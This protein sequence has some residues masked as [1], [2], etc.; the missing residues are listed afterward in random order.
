MNRSFFKIVFVLFSLL[1]L[2][3]PAAVFAPTMPTSLHGTV[4]VSSLHAPAGTGIIAKIG[5]TQKG[6]VAVVTEGSYG[7]GGDP[8]LL[9][10]G[11]PYDYG[12]TITLWVKSPYMQD[13][14]QADQTTIY[15]S[16][17][18]QVDITTPIDTTPPTIS[19]GVNPASLTYD[20]T[21]ATVDIADVGTCSDSGYG[22]HKTQ[23][24]QVSY[25]DVGTTPQAPCNASAIYIVNRNWGTSHDAGFNAT[26]GHYYCIRLD[27]MD[28]LN[29]TGSF[30]S[31][32]NILY[33]ITPPTT[34]DNIPPGW[35][36]SDIT[37]TLTC[38]DTA[39]GCSKVYYTTN[40]TDPTTS[41]DYVD[42]SDSWQFTVST[43]GNHTIKYR[44]EDNAG[45]L[46]PANTATLKIDKTPP[47]ITVTNTSIPNENQTI[48]LNATVIDDNLDTVW[49]EVTVN[50]NSTNYTISTCMG[51]EYHITLESSNYTAHDTVTWQYHANDSPG[52]QGSGPLRAFTVKNRPPSVTAPALNNT[53]PKTDDALSCENGTFSDDDAEDSETGR[54]YRWYDNNTII[55]G[56]TS[57]TLDLSLGGLDKN[58][59][60]KCSIRVYDGYGWSG[61]VYSDTATIQNTAPTTPTSLAL[62]DPV[63]VGE[64]LAAS[65]SGSADAD[66]DPITYHY[67]FYNDTAQLQAYSTD[68]TYLIQA[69]DAHDL[70][71][72]RAKAYDGTSYSGEKENNITVSNTAPTITITEP[73]GTN[74]STKTT[75]TVTWTAT[76]AE[77]DPLAIGCYGDA[78]NSGYDKTYTCFTGT[79]NNG[80]RTCNI[81]LWNDSF[82]Y[83]WC[84]ATDG[85]DS[86]AGYSPG[87]LAVDKTPPSISISDDA[88]ATW[89]NSDT[90]SVTVDDAT[91]GISETKYIVSDDNTCGPAKDALLDAGTPGTSVTANNVSTYQ[92][93]YI[94][95]RT[96]DNAGNKNY[97]VSSQITKLD[98]TSPSTSDNVPSGWHTSDITV[99][100]ACNDTASGCSKVYYTT[101]GT[102][103]TT[104]SGYVDASGIWQFTISTDGEYTIKYRGEDN[105]GNLESVNTAANILRLDKTPPTISIS[106]DAS[107]TWTNS[108]TISVTVDDATSGISE[109][110]YIV[111][112]DN[113]CGPAKDALLDAGTSTT[114]VT[115]NVSA[116]QNK[117][118]CF[119]TKDTAGNKNYAVSSQIT[120]LD[121]TSPSTSDNVPSGWHTSDITVTLACNDTDSGCS[122]VYYTTG[123]TDPTTASGYVDASG[124]WQFTVS[125]DGEYTIKY[126]GEDNA[127]NLESVNTAA[128]T[129]R[130][131][132]TAPTITV[133]NTSIP[134]EDQTIQLNATVIDD[135]LDT[136]WVEVTVNSNSTNYTVSTCID[137]EYHITLESSN[138]TAHDIV[139]WQYHANDS[140]GNLG[141]GPLRTFTVKNQVPSVTA[142]ALN[143]TTPKTDDALSCEN[144]TFSDDDTEDSETGREYRWHNND[145]EIPGQTSHTLDLS[146]GGLDKNDMIKCSIRA[147]DG[148]D[149]SGWVNSD[150][151]AI[152]NTAP[153][154]PAAL[155]LTDPIHV[156]ETLAASGSG[157]ADADGDPITYHYS[158]YND[159]A[160]LQAYS[161]DNTYVILTSD[162]HDQIMV[163]AKAYDGTDYS[164]EKEKN[165]T[166]SNKVPTITITEPD[167]T[168]DSIKATF[169]VTWTATDADTD[170]LA[171]DCYGDADN[172]GYDKTY[173]CF[174][175]TANN[176][177]KTCDI[178]LWND[179]FYYIWCNATDGYDSSAGYSPG[180][181]AVDKTPPTI[182]GQVKDK[183]PDEDENV[184]L[185]ATIID[186]GSG[187][188]T[189]LLEWNR[190]TNYTV[191]TYNGNTY[192]FTVSHG[193]YTAHDL[194]YWR[195]YADDILSNSGVGTEQSFTVANQVPTL[196]SVNANDSYAKN[197]DHIKISTTGASDNDAE[198][199]YRLMC[200]SA[201][202]TYDYCNGTYGTGERECNFINSWSNNSVYTIHCKLYDQ[203]GYSTDR[204]TTSGCAPNWVLNHTWSACIN[205]IQ[206]NEYYD[207]NDCDDTQ[208]KP[209]DVKRYCELGVG[210]YRD[211]PDIATIGE[212]FNVTLTIDV[213]ESN[214]PGV[215][216]LYEHIPEGFEIIDTGGM[217]PSG[218]TLK[219]MVFESAYYGTLVEDRIVTYTLRYVTVNE[220]VFEGIIVY[221]SVDHEVLGDDSISGVADV[222]PPD[223]TIFSPVN[224][225]YDMKTVFLMANSGEVAR[226]MNESIDGASPAFV[227]ADCSYI[228][229]NI[230][231]ENGDHNI[232][233]YAT[234]YAGNTGNATVHFTIDYCEP[235]WV[236]N[237]TWSECVDGFQY[238]NYYDVA[239]CGKP[240]ERPP[241]VVRTC[242]LPPPPIGTFRVLPPSAGIGDEFDVVLNIDV[243]ESIKPNVYIIY[244]TIPAGFSVIDTG[245]MQYTT[246]TR[247]LKLMVY[248]SAYFGTVVE[249]RIVTYRLRADAYPLEVFDG[250]LRYD[251]E[252]HDIMGDI[253]VV[254]E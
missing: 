95:F 129:L 223:V 61:W 31:S 221:D 51:S 171:I 25:A 77:T 33:D 249:D 93:K 186:A 75:F 28:A 63:H 108:D 113:T 117:Y 227:C 180:Q 85:Y 214:K 155:A 184:V 211:L 160:Q 83:I 142:P 235:I 159:T 56:Q 141:S 209:S 140:P 232:T 193:N 72:I 205:T 4:N 126:M 170:P 165:I 78:D 253:W 151:A 22:M 162:A 206:Y 166:V 250:Y 34:S 196:T 224:T 53:T 49:V 248:E 36:T 229:H 138:Y 96:K 99:T 139:T 120:K 194:V 26:D 182:S 234:D 168:N 64:T 5:S 146:L 158:F 39:S 60:I 86:S 152:Q 55:S 50:G 157:S 167:G 179:S 251:F 47:S 19:T 254:V 115:A 58:D 122:K 164:G 247:T 218:N 82:Y 14:I 52:N 239:N 185:N 149:W 178:S 35:H 220:S 150:T 207:L 54:K 134:N 8:Q 228:A 12:S 161:T 244:E 57:Q 131:D 210:I 128:N 106:D 225:T 252:N 144:G 148:Y 10:L 175:G 201:E 41:S 84:N 189:V 21:A 238:R 156:G 13:Y 147:Y 16:S 132:K 73:D 240:E 48:Q 44:G 62:T 15:D 177:S 243:N 208:S 143:N 226:E 67:S 195:Y 119:R 212:V 91:S 174:T 46:E 172:L 200:G 127:G 80:S 112:D 198:D 109:T 118:I 176:G 6:S 116:Y 89:T 94:C 43:D 216:I 145:T 135:N 90:I 237:D 121:T 236:L 173:T 3:M 231:F 203:Y 242:G 230:T 87:Q 114:S 219:L 27:C 68:N 102:D 1:F 124:I 98:T 74:D 37:V 111:S 246:A 190:T 213:N 40:G 38:I 81:S 136:V 163:R 169:T 202:D 9:V 204:T 24:Y 110:K 65:C 125:T 18:K 153:A 88:S 104:S 66:G 215:Y 191:T 79:A 187:L 199:T 181:L 154:T 71:R 2:L 100:L 70:I 188:G 217:S 29:N 241:D 17:V 222:T 101:G 183:T 30:Y 59:M 32:N 69:S 45:N 97:A 137:S 107:A 105:A 197:G 20:N 103:P 123:G 133:T 130:L 76:D 92:N 245:G 192:Y 42:A 11:E 23:P 7:M 233:V